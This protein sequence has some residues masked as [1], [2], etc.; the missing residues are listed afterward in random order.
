MASRRHLLPT[1]AAPAA[2]QFFSAPD[3]YEIVLHEFDW[4]TA[5]EDEDPHYWTVSDIRLGGRSVR[6]DWGQYGWPR[7]QWF[8]SRDEALEFGASLCEW[9]RDHHVW[10]RPASGATPPPLGEETP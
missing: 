6:P 7:V 10:W 9:H 1:D 4:P 5:R 2:S 8:R 3:A